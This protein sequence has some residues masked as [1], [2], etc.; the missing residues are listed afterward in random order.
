[1]AAAPPTDERA[2]C[3]TKRKV[4][5]ANARPV[6]CERDIS[7]PRGHGAQVPARVSNRVGVRRVRSLRGFLRNFVLSRKSA[8][9][10]RQSDVVSFACV[11]H[12]TRTH[13][14]TRARAR[15]A[16]SARTPH[17]EKDV[18]AR[19]SLRARRIASG[20]CHRDFRTCGRVCM[21]A[22]ERKTEETKESRRFGEVKRARRRTCS[23]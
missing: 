21:H 20:E 12:C 9:R 15:A 4:M 19:T 2:R 8:L 10:A 13:V 14:R 17:R 23:I 11:A 16:R 3:D 18:P 1:M 7:P 6:S 22:R 5:L